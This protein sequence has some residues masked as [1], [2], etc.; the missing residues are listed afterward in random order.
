M[1]W[2]LIEFIII[3]ALLL[4]FVF[5][6]IDNKCDIN[7]GFTRIRDAPVY[8]TVF[9][10][11]IIGMAVAFLAAFVFK[12]GKTRRG[13]TQ[14]GKNQSGKNPGSKDEKPGLP[15]K[16]QTWKKTGE[17]SKTETKGADSGHYG[18]D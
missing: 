12:H 5:F 14:D 7:F 17:H 1:P 15:A 4:I 6:N 13:K 18:I 16:K 11:F 10:S 2:R 8:L 3:F 9:T